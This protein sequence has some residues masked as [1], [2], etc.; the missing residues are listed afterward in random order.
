MFDHFPE[1]FKNDFAKRKI[2]LGK[3][4]LLYIEDFDIDHEK[5]VILV[6]N[7]IDDIDVG[8]VTINSIINENVNYNTYL[9]SLNIKILKSEHSFL[10]YDSFVDC[11]ELRK[12]DKQELINYLKKNPEKAVGN[13]EKNLFKKIKRT[14]SKA[15]TID[16]FTKKR[17]QF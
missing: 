3:S 13:I 11:S 8:Y 7:S 15:G 9:K 6:A 5:F 10:K 12:F 4:I 1:E 2:D 14:I 16:K 17:F